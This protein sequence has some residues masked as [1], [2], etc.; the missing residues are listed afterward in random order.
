MID[1]TL[2]STNAGG[3]ILGYA[4]STDAE[5]RGARGATDPAAR[6]DPMVSRI[7]GSAS[8]S[9]AAAGWGDAV[10]VS[11]VSQD[12]AADLIADRALAERISVLRERIA[13]GAY[14]SPEKLDVVADRL[15]GELF[16]R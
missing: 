16:G 12:P 15:H 6:S 14:L 5:L 3:A 9:G 2:V 7:G 4:S 10:E 1:V 11:V 8:E 13:A